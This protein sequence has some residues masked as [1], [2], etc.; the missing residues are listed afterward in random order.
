MPSLRHIVMTHEQKRKEQ[1]YRDYLMRSREWN[2][3]QAIAYL[4]QM[5]ADDERRHQRPQ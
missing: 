2:E 3:E 5:R 1:Q 4:Q